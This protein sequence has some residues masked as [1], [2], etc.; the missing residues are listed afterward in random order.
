MDDDTFH[1]AAFA[2]LANKFSSRMKTIDALTATDTT[3]LEAGEACIS[4]MVNR[5]KDIDRAKCEYF[6]ALNILAMAS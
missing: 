2:D 6:V 1:N 3:L 5:Q 4:K